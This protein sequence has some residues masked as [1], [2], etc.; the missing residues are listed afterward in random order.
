LESIQ[1]DDSAWPLVVLRYPKVIDHDDFMRHLERVVGY[2]KRRE[3]WGMIN[4]SRGSGHP[5]AKQRQAIANL[6]DA[7]EDSVRGFWRGTAI[8]FDS[9]VTVGVVTALT[10]LRPA[11]HPFKAFTDYDEGRSWVLSALPPGSIRPL[12]NVG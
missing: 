2:V 7:H 6:Y 1:F 9:S 11:P 3:P 8:I 5:N 10:W 4:D 12:R